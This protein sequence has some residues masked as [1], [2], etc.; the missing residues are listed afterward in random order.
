MN[1]DLPQRTFCALLDELIPARDA[2]LPGAGSLGVGTY[3]EARL[4]D[5][6]PLV[7]S[8]LAALDALAR[9]RG[10]AEFA[11]LQ[12]A[13]RAPLVGEVAAGHPGFV[14]LLVFHTYSGYYQNPRVSVAIGM[15]L[16][17][18]LVARVQKS[19]QIFPSDSLDGPPRTP[20]RQCFIW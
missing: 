15:I 9:E 8:G 3:V 12:P 10:A 19:I 20:T 5:A 16:H 11:D 7:A 17:R 14:E 18:L 4:A 6:A 1:D 13:E 2:S